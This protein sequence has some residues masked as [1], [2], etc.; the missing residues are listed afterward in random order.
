MLVI[1]LKV[2]FTTIRVLCNSKGIIMQG[3]DH[4]QVYEWVMFVRTLSKELMLVKCEKLPAQAA[5]IKSGMTR[6]RKGLLKWL[7]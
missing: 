4:L 2:H 5:S 3:I 1:N 7:F 6:P